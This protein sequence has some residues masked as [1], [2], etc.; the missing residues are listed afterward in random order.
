MNT[1]TL[2]LVF[3]LALMISFTS[4][5]KIYQWT[6]AEGKTHFSD[7][8]PDQY[9]HKEIKIAAKLAAG[10]KSHPNV[11]KHFSGGSKSNVNRVNKPKVSSEEKAKDIAR[12]NRYKEKYER[13][14]REGILGYNVATGQKRMMT[15]SEE[16]HWLKSAKENMEIMCS[17]I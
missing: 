1:F 4:V 8:P 6:D 17:G 10:S 5:A 12:C 9:A 3:A 2:L 14:K 13:Y 16:K 7:I 11:H 15:K